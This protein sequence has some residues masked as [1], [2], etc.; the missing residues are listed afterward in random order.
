MPLRNAKGKAPPTRS[1]CI[2]EEGILGRWL[3]VEVVGIDR[4]S[5]FDRDY[6]AIAIAIGVSAAMGVGS[7]RP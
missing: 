5:R 4:F 2:T 3:E 7:V 1:V 6:V